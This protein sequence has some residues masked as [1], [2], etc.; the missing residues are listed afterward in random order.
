MTGEQQW[1]QQAKAGNQQGFTKLYQLHVDRLFRFLLQFSADRHLVADWVQQT[2]I[3]A[4]GNLHH[5]EERSGFSTW[6]IRIGINEMKSHFRK[7]HVLDFHEEISEPSPDES[8]L[9][10]YDV[11]HIR[12][13][14]DQLDEKYRMVFLLYEVEGFSH[15]EIADIL[16]L[17]VSASR[18]ILT[19]AKAKLRTLLED[20]A[21]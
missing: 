4:F 11:E 9:D 13:C 16:E 2:F 18:T 10:G 12:K 6:L 15:A 1:I 3:K 19:R 17:G 20:F 7:T 14:V 8:P 21:S 5:F